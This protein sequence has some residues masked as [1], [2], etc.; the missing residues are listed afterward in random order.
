[1]S[2]TSPSFPDVVVPYEPFPG[3]IGVLPSAETVALKLEHHATEAPCELPVGANGFHESRGGVR[4]LH[5]VALG[6]KAQRP[7]SRAA[8]GK[9]GRKGKDP[10]TPYKG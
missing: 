6:P 1:M 9:L 4:S 5:A 2:W 10:R 3:S 8:A 7:P